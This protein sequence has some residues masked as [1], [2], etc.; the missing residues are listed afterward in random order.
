MA[1]S[2][3]ALMADV[4]EKISQMNTAISTANGAAAEAASAKDTANTETEKAVEA[5]NAANTAAQEAQ[6]ETEAWN[7]AAATAETIAYGATPRVTITEEDGAKKLHYKIPAGK[8]GEKGDPGADG[9]SGV[10]FRLDGT[11]LYITTEG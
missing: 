3:N 2:F 8:P 11:K 4:N 10:T 5:T 6:A 1:N 9:K 7:S